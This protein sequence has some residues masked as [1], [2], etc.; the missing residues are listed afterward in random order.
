MSGPPYITINV[1]PHPTNIPISGDLSYGFN[2]LAANNF[3]IL[4]MAKNAFHIYTLPTMGS[5]TIPVGMAFMFTFLAM[6]ISH[7]NVRVAA[8]LGMLFGGGILFASGSLGI[9][10]PV[11]LASLG[12]GALLASVAGLVMSIFKN[13]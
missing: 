13:T 8:I 9:S 1:T 4:D 12:Y 3:S 10:A 11:E 7:K 5:L 6:W 2:Q